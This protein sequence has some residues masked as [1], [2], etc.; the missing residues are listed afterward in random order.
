MAW[1][2]GFNLGTETEVLALSCVLS[3]WSINWE[4][5][6]ATWGHS[7]S[8]NKMFDMKTFTREAM[9][10]ILRIMFYH[11]SSNNI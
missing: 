11:K 5:A 8:S 2:L 10:E 6:T 1:R 7:T 3:E 4:P 9:R